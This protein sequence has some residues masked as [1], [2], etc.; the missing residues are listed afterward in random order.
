MIRL[1]TLQGKKIR[2]WVAFAEGV[3]VV[4]SYGQQGGKFTEKRYTAKPKNEGKANATTAEE[5][6]LKEV[7]A[8]VVKQLKT[9][10]FRTEE[11][12]T[13]Y[14][15]FFP[16]KAQDFRKNPEKIV[17]PCYA[18][19]KLDGQRC[20]LDAKGHGLSK[21]GEPLRLPDHWGGIPTLAEKYGGMDGEV[22]AGLKN[23]GGLSLQ[24][25]ISAFRK[26]NENTSMLKYYVYDIPLSGEMFH[27]R[28][29]ELDLL[30]QDAEAAKLPLVVVETV[31]IEDEGQ[32]E[33]YFKKC[34]DEGYEGIVIRNKK[35]LYEFDKRSYDLLKYKPRFTA[36]ALVLGVE[37]DKNEDGVL[38]VKALN[39]E[40]TD[41]RFKLLM[42]KDADP[43][44]NYRKF[45]AAR[46]L[47]DTTIEYEFE[48][49]SDELVPLKPVGVRLR[50]IGENGE[51][52]Y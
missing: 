19:P 10:Y 21:Q 7:E 9:G 44:V 40:Q 48:D 23:K 14:I 13:N 18:Q 11:E 49:L 4:V 33:A 12:A 28:R 32:L 41:Q 38:L 29:V 5:Q 20:M 15:P 17:Y 6:A 31:R 26:E 2:E 25:I 45:D 50:E 39:G 34:L 36:E 22:Y 37:V 35:G 24:E 30:R 43:V 1:Y 8:L 51:S 46:T 42:R 27:I 47:I 16:M 3:E 52:R